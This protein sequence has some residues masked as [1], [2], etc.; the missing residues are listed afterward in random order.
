[1]IP[2]QIVMI[3]TGHGVGEDDESEKTHVAVECAREH[4]EGHEHEGREARDESQGHH[5]LERREPV[6]RVNI[7]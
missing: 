7:N 1:M 3:L 5:R 6:C 2:D 4:V